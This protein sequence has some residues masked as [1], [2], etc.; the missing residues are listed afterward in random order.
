MEVADVLIQHTILHKTN[1][2]GV[3]D[4]QLQ[5]HAQSP[6]MDDNIPAVD[7]DRI[8]KLVTEMDDKDITT[9]LEVLTILKQ[10]KKIMRLNPRYCYK[11]YLDHD[12]TSEA[13]SRYDQ[14]APLRTYLQ[15]P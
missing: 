15:L 13:Q 10:M 4:E 14:S 2:I 3:Q 7:N 12:E 5:C 1:S 6:Q 11:P 9:S 8:H